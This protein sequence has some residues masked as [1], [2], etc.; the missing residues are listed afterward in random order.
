MTHAAHRRAHWTEAGS[1]EPVVLIH[2]LG[3]DASFWDDEVAAWS[4]DF[5]LLAVDLRG[6]GLTPSSPATFSI[7]DLADDIAEVLD[8]ASIDR[9]H[10]VGFS[11]GGLVAQQFA[12]AHH[13]R[14]GR[15]ALV[16]TYAQ[17]HRQAE[18]FLDAV[19]TVYEQSRSDALMYELIAPWLFSPEFV[20]DPAN[21]NYF[22]FPAEAADEQS[23][24]DWLALYR[25]QKEFNSTA[26]LPGIAAQTLVIAGERDALVPLHDAETLAR[27]IPDARLAR[28]T[29]SG[30]LLN[31][32][33]PHRFQRCV[34]EFLKT[35]G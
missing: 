5:R 24:E 15:M 32:E 6:S 26:R 29:Q 7:A 34:R 31:I 17:M 35:P 27:A 9:A 33:E 3:G 20:G 1:G 18:F 12:V 23:V 19:A 28:F 13:A 4:D 30:H 16:S 11:L 21:E 22:A 2:G 10:V 14:V 8:E 25:S